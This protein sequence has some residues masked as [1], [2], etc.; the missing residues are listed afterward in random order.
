MMMDGHSTMM[1]DLVKK[2]IMNRE[3]MLP[4]GKMMMDGKQMMIDSHDQMMMR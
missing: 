1:E 2:G 3:D 4:G